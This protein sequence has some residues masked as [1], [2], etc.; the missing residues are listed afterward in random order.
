MQQ[1]REQ[2]N[3]RIT[4]WYMLRDA[5]R[6]CSSSSSS[7]LDEQN[8]QLSKDCLRQLLQAKKREKLRVV[9]E[10]ELVDLLFN[11]HKIAKQERM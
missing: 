7:S 9:K 4:D 1:I 2:I 8:L 6:A 3:A 5:V 11:S 10:N